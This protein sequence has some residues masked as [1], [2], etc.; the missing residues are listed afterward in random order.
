MLKRG[1]EGWG[2]VLIAVK[3]MRL[4]G[5]ASSAVVPVMQVMQFFGFADCASCSG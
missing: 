4:C 3:V 2:G 1:A 5:Y